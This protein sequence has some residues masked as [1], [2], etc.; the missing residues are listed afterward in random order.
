MT[1]DTSQTADTTKRRRSNTRRRLLDAA[2]AVYSEVGF[3]RTTVEKVVERAGFTRGAF[4]S[5]FDSREA[6]FLAMWLERST[7]MIA[8]LEVALEQLA[9]DDVVDLSEAIQGIVEVLPVDARWYAITIEV[10][11][12]ALRDPDL[13]QAVALREAAIS[14]ALLPIFT[15][16][17]ER[18]N[19]QIP[20]PNALMQALVAV[21][22]GTT[23]QVLLE[24]DDVAVRQRRATLFEHVVR[25][26]T[27][28][29]Q[30]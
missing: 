26:Y 27:V 8:D 2:F 7:Q 6:L 9:A 11:A 25:A 10:T 28:A 24:P 14:E 15:S 30:E 17:L 21:Y 3:G 29:D 18:I 13:R 19:R 16:Q 22:D 5:N 12:H 23:Q 1:P 4:Y 20:D